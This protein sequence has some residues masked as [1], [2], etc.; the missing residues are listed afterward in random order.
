MLDITQQARHMIR[1]QFRIQLPAHLWVAGVSTA[2]PQ[3]TFR[4]LSGIKTGETAVELGE[5]VT[6]EP[7]AVVEATRAHEAITAYELPEPD[8]RRVLAK[9]ETT[10]TDL[11]EFVQSSSLTIEF[12]VTVANGW[13]EFSLTGTRE[14]LDRFQAALD[15]RSRAYELRSLVRTTETDGLLTARQREVLEAAVRAGYFEVPRQSTLAEVA[16]GLDVDK[17]T[18]SGVLRRAQGRLGWSSG[19]SPIPH[20]RRRRDRHTVEHPIPPTGPS[21]PDCRPLGLPEPPRPPAVGPVAVG[22]SVERP[23]KHRDIHQPGKKLSGSC[24]GTLGTESDEH[25]V[26][27]PHRSHEPDEPGDRR[28]AE[29][30]VRDADERA[31]DVADRVP[32][33]RGPGDRERQIRRPHAVRVGPNRVNDCVDAL[34]GRPPEREQ[35]GNEQRGRQHADDT[36]GRDAGVSGVVLFNH[37][38]PRWAKPGPQRPTGTVIR[39]WFQPLT[40]TQ[41]NEKPLGYLGPPTPFD[42]SH[43]TSV[44]GC[45]WC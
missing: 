23:A 39:R 2:F 8:G 12:P 30:A 26:G 13:Y 32:R 20:P 29:P 43:N 40:H 44:R 11:Y 21:Y 41:V 25:G 16:A 35:P 45:G 36:P 4:L 31:T 10:D 6:D 18:A 19:F 5:T 22:V 7:A 34:D 27:N 38:G 42:H 24:R 37:W 28:D 14:E 15:G 17:S 33:E 9:Y 1:A 3:T